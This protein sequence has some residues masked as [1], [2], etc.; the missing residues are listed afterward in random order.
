MAKSRKVYGEDSEETTG[1]LAER[2]SPIP[3]PRLCTHLQGHERIL[4]TL[5]EA[6]QGE[7][8]PHG[9][10]LQGDRGIG[11]ATLAYQFIERVFSA[12]LT[13]A[14][15]T[16]QE[17]RT[18]LHQGSHP[19]LWVLEAEEGAP[20]SVERVRE[21]L[22]FLHHTPVWGGWRIALID[23]AEALTRQAAN[24]LL[25]MLE[26]P[27]H[28]TLLLLVTVGQ[29]LPTLR[30][31]C[32]VQRVPPLAP[33][34]VQHLVT[35]LGRD[36]LSASLLSLAQGSVGAALQ[37][38]QAPASEFIHYLDD[39]WRG[40]GDASF[41]SLLE[42]S[43]QWEKN[44][45]GARALILLWLAARGREVARQEAPQNGGA[46]AQAWGQLTALFAEGI[47]SHLDPLQT[48]T[49]ALWALKRALS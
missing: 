7:R 46:F 35:R 18:A 49:R 45:E 8:P 14:G 17:V 4:E 37:L 41:A 48:L 23:G 36:P 32:R 19:D 31:R 27:P 11:K 9:W 42:V 25:K 6:H 47:G 29:V 40:N 26:E 13:A 10:I 12:T 5:W 30:S 38:S 34:L 39:L 1:S 22:Y 44:L 2:R 16:R 3:H 33:D 43:R 21:M 28:R 15:P 24:G 20:L